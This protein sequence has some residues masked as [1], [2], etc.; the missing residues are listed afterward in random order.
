[1]SSPRQII[2]RE[3]ILEHDVLVA[4]FILNQTVDDG[5]SSLRWVI[6]VVNADHL[7]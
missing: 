6:S 7:I 5:E 3:F 4:I 1:M 2:Y